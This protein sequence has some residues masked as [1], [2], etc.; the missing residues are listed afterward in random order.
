VKLLKLLFVLS[1][2]FFSFQV[3]GA[4]AGDDD[5]VSVTVSDS[6]ELSSPTFEVPGNTTVGTTEDGE[7]VEFNAMA[8]DTNSSFYFS[9]VN[10]GNKNVTFTMNLSVLDENGSAV[11]LEKQQ[12]LA[13]ENYEPFND[14][15]TYFM[16]NDEDATPLGNTYQIYVKD[17]VSDYERGRYTGVLNVN[18]SCGDINASGSYNRSKD[19]W[20]IEAETTEGGSQKGDPE[21]DET[22]PEEANQT[23]NYT[24]NITVPQDANQS[25]NYTSNITAPQNANE[26]GNY[27]SNVTA[28]RE[29]NQT[30]NYTSNIT[31]PAQSNLTDNTSTNSSTPDLGGNQTSELDR[32]ANANRTG[33]F[34]TNTTLPA[35]ANRTGEE[36]NQTIEGDN[37]NPGQTPEPEPEPEPEPGDSPEPGESDQPRLE[38]DLEPTNNTY[39]AFQGQY[40]PAELQVENIGEDEVTDIQLLPQIENVREGW[41]SRNA[42]VANLSV[43]ETVTRDVFVRPPEDQRPGD[44]LIPV[45]AANPDRQLDLDYFTVEVKQSEFAPRVTI[46]EAPRT[47]TANTNDNQSLPVLIENPGRRDISNVTAE[48]QNAE[49]CGEVSAS[50]VSQLSV[51]GTESLQVDIQTGENAQ[52]CSATLIVS[53]ED[54]AYAFSDVQLDVTP[55]EG[56]IPQEQ[57]VP[58]VAIIWTF[59]LAGYAILRKR[60][61]LTSSVT[62]IPF[63]LL[64]MGETVIILFMLVNYYGVM[65]VSFLPF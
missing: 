3:F 44:Y 36:S 48:L 52:S 2:I 59:L 29:S 51:N 63:F 60:Y 54:G 8:R 35:D 23:G 6:C 10:N 9:S 17:F 39:E 42:S 21:T 13:E 49:D 5:Q 12:D 20:I 27:T 64:L 58:L 32:P 47:V 61:N 7:T 56:L 65:S 11:D 62:Q 30:G 22:A 53:S 57:R 14:N 18:Y 38:I 43:N 25:G 26:S 40:T 50:T 46:Q 33:N 55:E 31:T 28:P 41:E 24:S 37:D 34:T 1:M 19:F 15:L 16:P 45:V 4:E